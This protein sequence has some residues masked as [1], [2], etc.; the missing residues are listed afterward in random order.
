MFGEGNLPVTGGVALT[1]LVYGA[2]SLFVTG[3]LIGERMIAKSGWENQC[4]S[5]LVRAIESEQRAAVPAIPDLDCDALIAPLF[6]SEGSRFCQRHGGFRLPF[7]DQLQA[8]KRRA[9]ELARRTLEGAAAKAGSRCSCAIA[10]TLTDERVSLAIAA[11]SLRLVVPRAASDLN[12]GLQSALG[13]DQC[14]MKG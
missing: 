7:A 12:S 13:S 6:G 1:A 3:P 2:I 4:R 8:Q 5:G 11:A 10:R 14:A 9:E